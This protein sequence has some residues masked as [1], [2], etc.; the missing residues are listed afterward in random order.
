[1]HLIRFVEKMSVRPYT[2]VSTHQNE[3]D[4]VH[5]PNTVLRSATMLSELEPEAHSKAAAEFGGPSQYMIEPELVS[6]KYLVM[7]FSYF[8]CGAYHSFAFAISVSSS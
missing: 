4:H 3:L 6:N 7:I 8:Y 5:V 2:H 1:M